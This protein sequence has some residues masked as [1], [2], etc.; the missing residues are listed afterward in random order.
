M[1]IWTWLARRRV[2]PPPE[3]AVVQEPPRFRAQSQWTMSTV[4]EALDRHERGDFA[5]TGRLM[6]ALLRDDEIS[7]LLQTRVSAVVGLKFRFEPEPGGILDDW[8]VVFPSEVQYGVFQ[9][10]LLMGF[11]LVQDE[12]TSNQDLPRW[13]P[14]PAESTRWSEEAQRYQVLT[15]QRGWVSVNPGDGHWA[16][17]ALAPRRA[18]M[19]GLIRPTPPMMVI[20]QATT[21]NWA[22]HAQVYATPSKVLKTNARDPEIDDVQ[23][24]ARRLRQMV[25]DSTII[26]PKGIELELIELEHATFQIYERLRRVIDDSLSI[27]YVGQAGT[28][29]AAGGWGSAQTERRVTQNLLQYDVKVLGA[30]HAQIVAPYDAWKRGTRYLS[31]VPRPIWDA[32]PPT[33]KTAR[34]NQVASIARARY[35]QANE[36][37]KLSKLDLG[38]GYRVDMQALCKKRGIPIWQPPPGSAPAP[39]A[40]GAAQK[41]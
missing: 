19:Y 36:L 37:E 1:S 35:D 2:E 17:F 4:E 6:Y 21:F 15:A 32:A 16:L 23:R 33:D 41:R 5:Q 29:K 10:T 7:A 26:L 9:T 25:G 30:A 31:Q 24:A 34:A 8:A 14:W 3:R 40:G 28:I 20:R 39:E 38:G 11:C 22:N 12:R 18:W 27:L 13:R